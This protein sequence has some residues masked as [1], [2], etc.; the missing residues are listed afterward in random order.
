MSD[1]NLLYNLSILN[2]F[3]N[4]LKIVEKR[5]TSGLGQIGQLNL[6]CNITGPDVTCN[7]SL[8]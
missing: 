8:Q 4:I 5:D 7:C 3:Y 1:N 2:T 6:L